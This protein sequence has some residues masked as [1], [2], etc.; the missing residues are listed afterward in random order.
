MTR[1]KRKKAGSHTT[2]TGSGSSTAISSGPVEEPT[3]QG[4]EQA[5]ESAPHMEIREEFKP[6]DTPQEEQSVNPEEPSEGSEPESA[7][8]A[9]TVSLWS[10]LASWLLGVAESLWSWLGRWLRGGEAPPSREAPPSPAPERKTSLSTA[11]STA[12][13]SVLSHF[14]PSESPEPPV[15]DVTTAGRRQPTP[16]VRRSEPPVPPPGPGQRGKAGSTAD[17]VLALL[18]LERL[19]PE[20]E[21][22]RRELTEYQVR[23]RKL[24]ME[25]D[26]SRA[27]AA[28]VR[29]E[30][31]EVEARAAMLG[32]AVDNLERQLI[33]TRET[34]EARIQQL[35]AEREQLTSQLASKEQEVSSF[36]QSAEPEQP[37]SSSL[38]VPLREAQERIQ[39]LETA[40]EEQQ[41][42][43]AGSLQQERNAAKSEAM[44]TAEPAAAPLA[45]EGGI[46][47]PPAVAAVLYERFVMRLTVLMANADLLLMNPRLEASV[48]E[49]VREI[50][51]EGQSLLEIIK[52]FT[53]PPEPHP[54]QKS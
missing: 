35:E 12:V 9:E 27:E 13:S 23:I 43:L 39:Q 48:Q 28:Q 24:E 1:K 25:R 38:E 2:A 7:P 18:T 49:S 14:R 15:E 6:A 20:L 52:E 36:R 50:K 54:P 10:R 51:T 31:R 8:P 40:L 53:Q 29:D 33:E 5:A 47:I 45:P 41:K 26:V 44:P 3:T 30:K 4:P 11:I 17:H 19:L 34:T 42:A 21:E 37:A 32:K 16:A 46:S 22:A